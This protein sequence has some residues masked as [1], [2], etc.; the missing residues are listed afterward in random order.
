MTPLNLNQLV[1]F[2]VPYQEDPIADF[3]NKENKLNRNEVHYLR[4]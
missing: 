2:A 4:G 3:R 1:A